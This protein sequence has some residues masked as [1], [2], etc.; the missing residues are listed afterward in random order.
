MPLIIGLVVLF[1]IYEVFRWLGE[2]LSPVFDV[3]AF[4]FDNFWV[5][6]GLA[7]FAGAAYIYYFLKPHPAEKYI[8]KY[9]EGKISRSLAVEKVA[10]TL[11]DH[12]KN[13]IPP[14][15]QSQYWAKRMDALTKR[16][17]AEEVFVEEVMRQIRKK[18]RMEE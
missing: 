7:C 6:F 17:Q 11:F 15:H 9:Q 18:S 14:A 10:D 1:F 8:R 16:V 5:F 2:F 3:F 12:N 4:I 13:K